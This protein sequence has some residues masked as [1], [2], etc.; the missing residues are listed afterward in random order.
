[1]S[2]T[3]VSGLFWPTFQKDDLKLPPPVWL[4]LPRPLGCSYNPMPSLSP[5]TEARGRRRSCTR[6]NPHLHGP[7]LALSSFTADACPEDACAALPRGCSAVEYVQRDEGRL[8]LT[9]TAPLTGCGVKVHSHGLRLC[10][11]G[12]MAELLDRY[13][14]RYHSLKAP[15]KLQWKHSLGT[16]LLEVTVGS[17][18]LE[19]SVTPAQ[20][21]LLMHFAEQ[22]AWPLPDL[23]ERMGV[24]SSAARKLALF[25]LNQGRATQPGLC[26]MIGEPIKLTGKRALREAV[27][28]SC[29][30]KPWNRGLN[31]VF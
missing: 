9:G 15:R 3:I 29:S 8:L 19:L 30:V 24:P 17:Q 7:T 28:P 31:W 10:V 27:N 13:G 6:G 4:R 1:M 23:A 11:Y 21:A 14:S 5:F 22:P 16:V 26:V 18:S 2:A 25:W 20:A 12:Q